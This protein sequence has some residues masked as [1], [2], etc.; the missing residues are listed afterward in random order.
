MRC[1]TI[2]TFTTDLK[3]PRPLAL[4]IDSNAQLQSWLQGGPTGPSAEISV[5]Y[6]KTQANACGSATPGN[7]G[8][9]DF[10]GG[11]NSS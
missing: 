9:L 10:D 3:G 11:T 8:L 6:A 7:L 1:G 2:Q 5:T 4:C